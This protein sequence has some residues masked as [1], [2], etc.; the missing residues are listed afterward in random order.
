MPTYT[1]Q[2][3]R[4]HATS[5]TVC[6]RVWVWDLVEGGVINPEFE[7]RFLYVPTLDA[8]LPDTLRMVLYE[9]SAYIPAH[10]RKEAMVRIHAKLER[11]R[12][13]APMPPKLPRPP[14]FNDEVKLAIEARGWR[15]EVETSR[16]DRPVKANEIPPHP[17]SFAK[18]MQAFLLDLA[19]Q[20]PF[21]LARLRPEYSAPGCERDQMPSLLNLQDGI[22]APWDPN[23][24]KWRDDLAD[25]RNRVRGI[26]N[27]IR[28]R[29]EKGGA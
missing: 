11:S 15:A 20:S 25:A 23:T 1:V 22:E 13:R 3:D 17:G 26:L 8:W 2:L 6:W 27:T 7:A 28:E 5:P 9:L 19:I 4:E 29:R 21:P 18:P 10:D 12:G 14:R 24:K 16:D